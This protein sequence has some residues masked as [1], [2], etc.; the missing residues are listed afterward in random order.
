MLF[1]TLLSLIYQYSDTRLLN[2]IATYRIKGVVVLNYQ[3]HSFLFQ[4]EIR[5]LYSL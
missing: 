5:R 1:Q 3:T 2:L 4:V